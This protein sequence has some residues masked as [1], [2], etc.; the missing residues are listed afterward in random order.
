MFKP[1]KMFHAQLLIPKIK[2][3]N[4]MIALHEAGVCELKKAEQDLMS[5]ETPDEKEIT[6]MKMIFSKLMSDLEEFKPVLQPENRI[7]ELL[8][9]KPPKKTKVDLFSNEEIL[10]V[11]TTEINI[12]KPKVETPLLELKEIKQ[13]IELND[14]EIANLSILPDEQTET[15]SSTK[16]LAVLFGII[17][18]KAV[19]QLTEKLKDSIYI[20]KEKDEKTDLIIIACKQSQKEN[21][22]KELHAVGFEPIK[23]NFSSSKPSEIIKELNEENIDLRKKIQELREKLFDAAKTYWA[24]IE[25]LSEQL[26]VCIDRAKHFEKL[27]AGKSFT[28]FEAWVPMKNLNQF[29]KIVKKETEEYYMLTEEREDAPT[30]LKNPKLI[31][32]FEM[33]TELYSVPKYGGLDPTPVIALTFPIFFGYMLTDFFYGVI[34]TLIAFVL[35][36]G[37]GK[38]SPGIKRFASVLIFLGISTTILGAVFTSYFGDFFPRIGITMPGILDPLQQV[39]IL[40]VLAIVI[41]VLHITLGLL[42]GFIN[43]IRL[44]KIMAAFSEQGV[45]LV[46]LIGV[47]L[48][49]LGNDFITFGLIAIT[50]SVV[51]RIFFKFLEGGP[52]IGM[53]SIFDFSG[54]IGDTFSYARL[55]ALAI[56]TSGIALAVN[57]MALLVYGMVPILGLPLAILV[58]FVGHL[59]NMVMNGLGAFIHSLRLHFLEFF[60]KFYEGGGTQYKPFY[61]KRKK[62]FGGE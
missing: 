50:L 15:F 5:L 40:I 9:P 27:K 20:L 7:K 59:F 18:K 16:N 19:S 1:A 47:V 51:M 21:I 14:F 62:T 43:N 26:D 35:Y 57:F 55:T 49:I 17:T 34:M 38:Y 4:L 45:W 30:L 3:Q 53:L 8:F 41:G 13:K 2:S 32:P 23:I 48:A 10:N 33:I 52:V 25:I 42:L 29:K 11:V 56:G 44:K 6:E 61:A 60:Q 24:K 22:E 54:F 31:R 37:I 36:A 46:F 28:L 39:V 12:I 58:F